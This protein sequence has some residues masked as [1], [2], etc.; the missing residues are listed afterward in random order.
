M[1]KAGQ[2]SCNMHSLTLEA[3]SYA[4]PNHSSGPTCR[5][6]T[7][8]EVGPGAT[9]GTLYQGYPLLLQQGRTRVVI[10]NYALRSGA[11]EPQGSGSYLTGQRPRTRSPLWDGSGDATCP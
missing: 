10:H 5:F 3:S 11:A 2:D 9:I 6:V 8:P 7:S 4:E 1:V